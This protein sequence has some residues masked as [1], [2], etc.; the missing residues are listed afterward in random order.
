MDTGVQKIWEAGFQIKRVLETA[1][2]YLLDDGFRIKNVFR[3]GVQFLSTPVS[4]LKMF[5]K[6]A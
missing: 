3:T 4:K 6:L 5:C 2:Q 1:V